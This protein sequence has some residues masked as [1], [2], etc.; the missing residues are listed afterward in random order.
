LGELGGSK[1]GKT[2]RKEHGIVAFRVES[3]CTIRAEC[4][5]ETFKARLAEKEE[6]SSSSP[7]GPCI[8]IK[9]QAGEQRRKAAPQEGR[10]TKGAS[11]FSRGT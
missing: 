4:T 9:E 10:R 8:A 5:A 7:Q 11:A 3:A 6:R 1:T 2:K